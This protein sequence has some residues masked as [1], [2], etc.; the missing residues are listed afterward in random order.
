MNSKVAT[1]PK[2]LM[3]LVV[4][5]R[6]EW[7]E[8]CQE[9]LRCGLCDEASFIKITFVETLEGTAP[10]S[11]TKKKKN[12]RE[13]LANELT[14]LWEEEQKKG[15]AAA[16]TTAGKQQQQQQQQQQQHQQQQQQ[17]QQQQGRLR[18]LSSLRSVKASQ[19]KYVDVSVLENDVKDLSAIEFSASFANFYLSM[20]AA[21]QQQVGEQREEQ[22]I[23]LDSRL[24]GKFDRCYLRTK[25]PALVL[26]K[27]R[28]LVRPGGW[29]IVRVTEDEEGSAEMMLT[30]R[31]MDWSSHS[32]ATTLV[33]MEEK[34]K[35]KDKDKN[36]DCL[37]SDN[38]CD[39]KLFK[40]VDYLVVTSGRKGTP[41][42][43]LPSCPCCQ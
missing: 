17:Q 29:C 14:L 16:G 8:L 34:E 10:T 35:E 30:C 41:F 43:R 24:I 21:Q 11:K 31:E 7:M 18:F 26:P 28:T 5:C 2:S 37:N 32:V 9:A 15:M 6:K 40:V 25:S 19:P 4:G 3:V 36:G 1:F 33:S 42:L 12:W 27:L 23:V 22:Q 39:T 38:S 13:E 20:F